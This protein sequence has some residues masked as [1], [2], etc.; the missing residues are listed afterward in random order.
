[1]YQLFR[2][3]VQKA[4]GR[5]LLSHILDERDDELLFRTR[6]RDVRESALFLNRNDSERFRYLLCTPFRT[7]VSARQKRESTLVPAACEHDGPLA[8]FGLCE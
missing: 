7:A 8:A 4:T 5:A 1:M 2:Y 6:H 3:L